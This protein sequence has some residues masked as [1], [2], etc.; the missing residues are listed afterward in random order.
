MS[1]AAA[2]IFTGLQLRHSSK[3]T[4]LQVFDTTFKDV[5]A[6]ER[7]VLAL[8]VETDTVL[9]EEDDPAAL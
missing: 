6:L 9:L 8:G 5:R 4:Q 1:T 3:A 2:A 7:R